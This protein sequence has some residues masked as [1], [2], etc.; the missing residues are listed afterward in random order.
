M[1]LAFALSACVCLKCFCLVVLFDI[2][3]YSYL[4]CVSVM[5]AHFD[6]IRCRLSRF[7][8]AGAA[9]HYID[10]SNGTL[11]SAG[12]DAPQIYNT[13]NKGFEEKRMDVYIV[14]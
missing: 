9:Y 2:M 12:R 14:S 6:I 8:R 4:H 5:Q 10:S 13:C 11:V 7:L 1:R 3:A